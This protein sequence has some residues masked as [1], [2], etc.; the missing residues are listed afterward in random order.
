MLGKYQ[1]HSRSRSEL[2]LIQIKPRYS[3]D[4]DKIQREHILMEHRFFPWGLSSV[5]RNGLLC[6]KLDERCWCLETPDGFSQNVELSLSPFSCAQS[7]P[8][9]EWSVWIYP[10]THLMVSYLPFRCGRCQSEDEVNPFLA[11]ICPCLG[12]FCFHPHLVHVDK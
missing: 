5:Q 3:L 10:L 11:R 2:D 6:A 8:C 7:C 4:L 9:Y 12:I 1:K